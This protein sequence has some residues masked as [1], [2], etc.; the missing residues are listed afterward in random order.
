MIIALELHSRDVYIIGSSKQA[1]MRAR[2]AMAEGAIVTLFRYGQTTES[3]NTDEIDDDIIVV[4]RRPKRRELRKPFLVIAC[5]RDKKLNRW[6]HRQSLK[7]RF[8]LNTLDEPKTANFSHV[9]TRRLFGS[10]DI[11]ISTNGTSP[12]F[13]GIFVDHL[14]SRTQDTDQLVYE[15]FKT[16]RKELKENGYSTFDF[17][18]RE[19]DS[20]LRSKENPTSKNHHQVNL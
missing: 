18:W 3:I 15:Q 7:K 1:L 5:D 11:A 6:I 16:T 8:L 2:V 19:L 13:G 14:K 17:D 9:A 12:A 10:V 20:T 4:D